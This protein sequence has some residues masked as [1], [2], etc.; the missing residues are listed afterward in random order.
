MIKIYFEFWRERSERKFFQRKTQLI[1]ELRFIYILPTI[2]GKF[3]CHL[4][5]RLFRQFLD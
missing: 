5:K 4:A 3:C 1:T 2:L